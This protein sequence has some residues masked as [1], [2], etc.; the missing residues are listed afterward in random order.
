MTLDELNTLPAESARHELERCCG[1]ERWASIVA[2][3]RPFQTL[4]ELLQVATDVWSSLDEQDWLAAFSQHPRIGERAEGWA[5]AEQ[6]GTQGASE[7]T[8]LSLAALNREYEDMF[9]YVF[10]ICATG[11]SADEVLS[12][13]RQRLT[14]D[15]G[16]ELQVAACEQE[17]IM[18]LRLEKLLSSP[19]ESSRLK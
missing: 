4:A 5:R 16:D 10:L 9:G 12:A 14:N 17:R 6:A 11:K 2:A 13:L 8:R 1:S 3:R 19:M 7:A 15:P 18:R